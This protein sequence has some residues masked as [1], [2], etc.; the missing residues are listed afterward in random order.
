MTRSAG[1]AVLLRI[2]GGT[3]CGADRSDDRGAG[4]AAVVGLAAAILLAAAIVA[5]AGAVAVA[6]HRAAAAADGA[7][8]AAAAGLAGLAPGEPCERAGEVAAASGG[9]LVDCRLDGLVATVAV[10]VPTPV[11]ESTVYATAG[12]PPD[13]SDR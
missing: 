5:P 13:R 6:W 12:P 10:S 8:L 9:R 7:A 4:T 1:A 3:G 2:G 11:A